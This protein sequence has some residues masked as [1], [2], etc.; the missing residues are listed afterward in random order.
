MFPAFESAASTFS[1]GSSEN[2][3]SSAFDQAQASAG[4]GGFFGGSNNEGGQQLSLFDRVNPVGGITELNNSNAGDSA[5]TNMFN[6]RAQNQGNLSITDKMR[7]IQGNR[8]DMDENVSIAE[9]YADA[10]L[11]TRVGGGQY[12]VTISNIYQDEKLYKAYHGLFT[13]GKITERENYQID[14]ESMKQ[15]NSDFAQGKSTGGL[16]G[17]FLKTPQQTKATAETNIQTTGVGLGLL[18]GAA[19]VGTINAVGN[20]G[21]PPQQF[22]GGQPLPGQQPAPPPLTPLQKTLQPKEPIKQEAPKENKPVMT[23]EEQIRAMLNASSLVDMSLSGELS[24]KNGGNTNNRLNFLKGNGG[25]QLKQ[26][27]FEKAADTFKEKLETAGQNKES[28]QNVLAAEEFKKSDAL[29]AGNSS[30][31]QAREISG[32]QVL[33][34]EE[35]INSLLTAMGAGAA[36]VVG[37]KTALPGQ[38]EQKQGLPSATAGLPNAKAGLPSAAGGAKE[39]GSTVGPNGAPNVMEQKRRAEQA[40]ADKKNASMYERADEIRAE[41]DLKKAIKWALNPVNKDVRNPYITKENYEQVMEEVKKARALDFSISEEDKNKTFES[42]RPQDEKVDEFIKEK[43]IGKKNVLEEEKEKAK[44]KQEEENE[45]QREQAELETKEKEFDRMAQIREAQAKRKF[46]EEQEENDKKRK[47]KKQEEELRKKP[48]DFSKN[49]TEML[50]EMIREGGG[51]ISFTEISSPGETAQESIK[52]NLNE[53]LASNS[54]YEALLESSGKANVRKEIERFANSQ[55]VNKNDIIKMAEEYQ[56]HVD[57]SDLEK[58]SLPTLSSLKRK[59]TEELES[60]KD[61]EQ[62]DALQAKIHAIQKAIAS[63]IS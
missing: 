5:T 27:P 24:S 56:K 53:H 39:I 29:Q 25:Q 63:K 13:D 28:A 30:D 47:R 52:T 62:R 22:Q 19:T 32:A 51:V 6:I 2:K 55:N 4:L 61:E 35:M 60:V 10:R 23:K 41:T 31:L 44:T 3:T 17:Q 33:N 8:L 1:F 12:N 40:E 54:D 21:L 46:V 58:L 14:V 49:Q 37:A 26:N 45:R 16:E 9:M 50:E 38:N 34:K 59:L 15:N 57:L 42:M 18:G 20:N 7:G 11:D 48:L 36:L 43:N